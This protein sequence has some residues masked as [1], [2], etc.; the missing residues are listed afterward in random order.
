MATNPSTYAPNVYKSWS[1][2][3]H[4]MNRNLPTV[5]KAIHKAE[6]GTWRKLRHKRRRH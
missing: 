3:Q 5:L 4:E 1:H 2:L 6:L